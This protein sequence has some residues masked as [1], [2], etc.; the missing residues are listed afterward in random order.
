MKSD[1]IRVTKRRTAFWSVVRGQRHLCLLT[2]KLKSHAVAYA[3]AIACSGK[4]VLFV[5]DSFGTAVRQ[6]SSSLTYPV[7]L[8]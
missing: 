8:D 3:R 7:V 6:S 2:F 1:F 4:L 5:D